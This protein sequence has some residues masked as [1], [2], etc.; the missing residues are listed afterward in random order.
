MSNFSIESW[1]K[2]RYLT[3]AGLSSSKAQSLAK[4]IDDSMEEIDSEMDYRDFA[5]AVSLVLKDQY[6]THNYDEFMKVLHS[7]LGMNE[8]SSNISEEDGLSLSEKAK[9]YF[10]QKVRSGEIDKLP[11]DPEEE[12]IFHKLKNQL[13]NSKIK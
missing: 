4:L 3:E 1:F 8:N 11:D 10:L 7:E 13:K 6:G 5:I 12:Y 9:I 2:D